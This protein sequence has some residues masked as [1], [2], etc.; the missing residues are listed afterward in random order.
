MCKALPES[1]NLYCHCKYMMKAYCQLCILSFDS[2]IG[3]KEKKDIFKEKILIML[4]I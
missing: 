3:S 1:N 2:S 4:Q